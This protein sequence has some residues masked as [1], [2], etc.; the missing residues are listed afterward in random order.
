M[1]VGMSADSPSLYLTFGLTSSF[2]IQMFAGTGLIVAATSLKRA[3]LFGAILFVVG[4][5]LLGLVYVAILV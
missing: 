4:L 2:A 5:G 3:K 1:L